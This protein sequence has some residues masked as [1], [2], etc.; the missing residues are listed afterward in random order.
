MNFFFFSTYYNSLIFKKFFY[1]EKKNKMIPIKTSKSYSNYFQKNFLRYFFSESSQ[2]NIKLNSLN[3]EGMIKKVD[4][5]NEKI[6]IIFLINFLKLISNFFFIFIF[7]KIFK[8]HLIY[9]IPSKKKFFIVHCKNI[10]EISYFYFNFFRCFSNTIFVSK[11]IYLCQKKS[12]FLDKK[13]EIFFQLNSSL[14]FFYKGEKKNLNLQDKNLFDLETLKKCFFFEKKTFLKIFLILLNS[15]NTMKKIYFKKIKIFSINVSL[16]KEY[17]YYRSFFLDAKKNPFFEDLILTEKWVKI[18][19]QNFYFEKENSKRKGI[20]KK[21]NKIKYL[22]LKSEYKNNF[23]IRFH[24][25]LIFKGGYNLLGRNLNIYKNSSLL[26]IIILGKWNFTNATKFLDY[27]IKKNSNKIHFFFAV[28][29]NFSD[30]KLKNNKLLKKKNKKFFLFYFLGKFFE[31]K[32]SKL[33]SILMNMS[34]FQ[35]FRFFMGVRKAKFKK[36]KRVLIYIKIFSLFFFQE[37]NDFFKKSPNNFFM[38]NYGSFKL[39]VKFVIIF[40]EKRPTLN[41]DIL[42]LKNNGIFL[43]KQK[44]KIVLAFI[45]DA[46][47]RKKISKK[48]KI[49]AFLYYFLIFLFRN[50]F[51]NSIHKD[52]ILINNRKIFRN[53]LLTILCVGSLKLI[54]ENKK[55]NQKKTIANFLKRNKYKNFI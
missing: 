45:L 3:H 6:F 39:I 11:Q 19:W 33:L 37:S 15:T 54:G 55:F 4:L 36:K 43:H 38:I 23:K 53:F 26:N 30:L 32:N 25:S 28:L 46:I 9:E 31:I 10:K 7:D 13:S 16:K 50:I 47:K 18:N 8:I 17:I 20:F 21:K 12:S 41:L 48:K 2:L 49:D 44:N 40:P 34:N 22:F 24:N 5:N 42:F 51:F 52:L 14:S 1:E 27:L 29:E 35:L